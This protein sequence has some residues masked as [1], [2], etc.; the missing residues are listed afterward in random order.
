MTL[1]NFISSMVIGLVMKGNAKE[2]LKYFF[3]L[4]AISMTIFFVVRTILSGILL[5]LFT[6][7]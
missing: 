3:P 1:S 7:I 5:G 6:S 4:V 2:G